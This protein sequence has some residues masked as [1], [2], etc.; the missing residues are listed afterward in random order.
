MARQESKEPCKKEACNIQACLSKNN[1]LPQKAKDLGNLKKTLTFIMGDVLANTMGGNIDPKKLT[2]SSMAS[3]LDNPNHPLYLHHSDQ[4][5]LGKKAT[6]I[7]D[8][9]ATDHIVRVEDGKE[10]ASHIV[11]SRKEALS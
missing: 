2:Q 8:S 11:K 9:G 1:F 6:W 3:K 4:P 10:T 5:G 7:L